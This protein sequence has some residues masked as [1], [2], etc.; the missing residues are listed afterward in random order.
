MA[1]ELI[2]MGRVKSGQFIPRGARCPSG[3]RSKKVYNPRTGLTMTQCM[4][5]KSHRKMGRARSGPMAL[6]PYYYGVEM[7]ATAAAPPLGIWVADEQKCPPKYRRV[8]MKMRREDRGG[9]KRDLWEDQCVLPET[10]E[11]Y[12][13][14][15]NPPGKRKRGPR[16]TYTVHAGQRRRRRPEGDV[17]VWRGGRQYKYPADPIRADRT[18]RKRSKRRRK[19]GGA[20]TPRKKAQYQRARVAGVSGTLGMPPRNPRTGRFMSYSTTRRRMSGTGTKSST[21]GR[22]GRGKRKYKKRMRGHERT[23]GRRLPSRGPGGRFRKRRRS[24]RRYRRRMSGVSRLGQRFPAPELW[25]MLGGNLVGSAASTFGQA[26]GVRFTGDVD[27]GMMWGALGV[28][29]ATGGLYWFQRGNTR[30]APFWLGTFL[31][32]LPNVVELITNRLAT[33]LFFPTARLSGARMGQRTFDAG[34]DLLT[35]YSTGPMTTIA[36][37]QGLGQT[38]EEMRRLQQLREFSTRRDGS[39]IAGSRLPFLR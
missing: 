21:L 19:R 25:K 3:M 33:Q 18:R 29:A 34:H 16:V 8:T 6:E 15:L 9:T 28:G 22:P 35:K 10:Y 4:V 7:P 12:G 23:L 14:P 36:G 20:S 24:P 32:S 13:P 30:W 39:I 11:E 2:E 31:G 38:Q 26:A 1:K 37:G 5:S 27:R 17:G